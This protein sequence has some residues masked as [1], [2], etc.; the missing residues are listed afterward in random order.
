MD[1]L[2]HI[3]NASF[4]L[5]QVHQSESAFLVNLKNLINHDD[6]FYQHYQHANYEIVN[7]DDIQAFMMSGLKYV[8]YNKAQI[9]P[10]SSTKLN[11]TILYKMFLVLEAN[12]RL[13]QLTL[14][15]RNIYQK[16][17][18]FFNWDNTHL[19]TLADAT[20]PQIYK[21]ILPASIMIACALIIW[22]ASWQGPASYY[23]MGFFVFAV[24]IAG[25]GI[26]AFYKRRYQSQI[27]SDYKYYS[28]EAIMQLFDHKI[29]GSTRNKLK[30]ELAGFS[31]S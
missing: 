15:Q 3:I 1:N 10:Q 2:N 29:S 23:G 24:L 13:H 14:Q 5:E 21:F 12:D 28:P 8:K 27:S 18:T 25:L 19:P 4:D 7:L 17:S 16:L 11:I 6:E 30:E 26:M 9:N 22:I 31:Q 20:T